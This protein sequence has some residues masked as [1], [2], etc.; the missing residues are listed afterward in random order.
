MPQYDPLLGGRAG[1]REQIV[2]ERG[3]LPGPW[4][5][6]LA[7][8]CCRPREEITWLEDPPG[9]VR[10]RPDLWLTVSHTGP[11]LEEEAVGFLHICWVEWA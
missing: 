11:V 5:S 1:V 10:P 8:W 2:P 7:A 6:L 9:T 4:T 3:Q